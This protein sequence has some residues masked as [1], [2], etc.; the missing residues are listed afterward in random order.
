MNGEKA[1]RLGENNFPLL[2]F[3]SK[4]NFKNWGGNVNFQPERYYKISNEAEI[5]ELIKLAKKENKKLRMVGTGHSWSDVFKTKDF[6]VNMDAFNKVVKLDTEKKLLTIQPGI[7][8]W[9]INEYLAE[10]GFA[11]AN[12]GSIAEQSI[13][14]AI[15][16][17]TH[18]SG[19]NYKMLGDQL[20]SFKLIDGKGEKHFIDRDK[21]YELFNTALVHLGALGI[22]T[23][24]TIKIVPSFQLHEKTEMV[25]FDLLCENY[26]EIIHSADYVKFWWFPPCSKILVY[27]YNRTNKAVNDSRF[28]QWFIDEFVSV[29]AYRLIVAIGNLNPNWRP[30]FNEI[31]SNYMIRPVDRI[32]Q[33]FK[34]FN[35]PSPPI[36][37]ETEW[38]FDINKGP[39]ILKAYKKM[40][41]EKSH[42]INFIQEIRFVK[43]DDF[44]LSPC[45][46]R[47]SIWIGTY[48]IGNKG[49]KALLTDFESMAK[50]YSGRPH[51][52][53]EFTCDKAYLQKAYPKLNDFI[54]MKNSF[55][56][57]NLFENRLLRKLFK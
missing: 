11:L 12:L 53:K 26:N 50:D 44:A 30:G 40:L 37:N 54:R 46:K 31:I 15:A 5:I 10:N 19:T 6:L 27:R 22:V 45:Y 24:I 20:Q 56:A 52:G 25:D 9:Q 23:E 1:L 14:G 36:H 51:W 41:E 39:E 48:L 43:G 3:I 29:Y 33:S 38:A 47:D 16:T 49:W 34:V 7:K 32:E 13:A 28:R 18:G 21:D 4:Y 57:S 2:K 17:G 42:K 35:V 8:L 55:D